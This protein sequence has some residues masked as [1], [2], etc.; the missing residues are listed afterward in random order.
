MSTTDVALALQKTPLG[1]FVQSAD[2]KLIEGAQLLHVLGLTLVL[3]TVLLLGLRLLGA[4]L[5]DVPLSRLARTV[6]PLWIT[7]LTVT[8][9]SGC[10]LFLSAALVYDHNRVFWTKLVLLL[11]AAAL[12][13]LLLLRVR[14]AQ[15]LGPALAPVLGAGSLLLWATVAISGRAIGFV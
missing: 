2:P 12:Q 11:V 15:A 8:V 4:L 10:T 6:T 5:R 1:L 13:A 3:A 7:G 9:L 14:R